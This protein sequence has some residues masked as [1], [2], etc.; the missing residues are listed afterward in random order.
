M[1]RPKYFVNGYGKKSL[2]RNVET[3]SND[4]ENN[5][6]EIDK[7]KNNDCEIIS[8]SSDDVSIEYFDAETVENMEEKKESG[9]T[10]EKR[11]HWE[12]FA[13]EED[14]LKKNA[15]EML[16]REFQV[17]IDF[18]NETRLTLKINAIKYFRRYANQISVY[19]SNKK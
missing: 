19:V 16:Q 9:M 1:K 5:D 18:L 15:K 10:I 6:N 14:Q 2:S 8:I 3:L 4:N 12:K 11:N 13:F 17:Q 7:N